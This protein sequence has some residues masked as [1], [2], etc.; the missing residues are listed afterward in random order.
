MLKWLV[1]ASKL[2]KNRGACCTAEWPYCS[3]AILST[4]HNEHHFIVFNT[5]YKEL[6]VSTGGYVIL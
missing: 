5:R 2:H 3:F 6:N 1:A 4:C